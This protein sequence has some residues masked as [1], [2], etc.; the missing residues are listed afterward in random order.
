MEIK[1]TCMIDYIPKNS[2]EKASRN[3]SRVETKHK[4]PVHCYHCAVHNTG[5]SN[6]RRLHLGLGVMSRK[7][8]ENS[9]I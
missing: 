1:F 5:E 9:A 2:D 3:H 6:P 7:V 4:L 8:V